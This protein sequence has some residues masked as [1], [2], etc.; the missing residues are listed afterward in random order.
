MVA[1]AAAG[2]AVANGLSLAR[3]NIKRCTEARLSINHGDHF[4][5]GI[6][7]QVYFMAK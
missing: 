4:K 1:G 2:Y 7:Q 6:K 5:I 3:P